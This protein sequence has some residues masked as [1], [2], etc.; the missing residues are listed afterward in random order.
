MPGA[1]TPSSYSSTNPTK[2]GDAVLVLG[3]ADGKVRGLDSAKAATTALN[4]A[5]KAIEFTGKAGAT[6]RIPSP[7]GVAAGSV[8]LV[9]L[10]S[11]DPAKSDDDTAD[12][13]TLRRAAGSALRALSVHRRSRSRCRSP[14]P[15]MSRP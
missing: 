8:L 4:D 9:G 2:A 6:V 3:V 5:A 10:G 11:F 1:S 12:R 7:K 14:P 15:R 13:E